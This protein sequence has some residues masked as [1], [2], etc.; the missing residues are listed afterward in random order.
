MSSSKNSI[1]GL[2]TWDQAIYINFS[3]PFWQALVPYLGLMYVLESEMCITLDDVG[4]CDEMYTVVCSEIT[5]VDTKSR[6]F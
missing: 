2:S 6:T 5:P 1:T 4:V 3:H